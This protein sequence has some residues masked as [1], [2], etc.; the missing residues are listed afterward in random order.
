MIDFYGGHGAYAPGLKRVRAYAIE[1]TPVNILD[2]RAPL[3][4]RCR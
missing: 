3:A 4:F 2:W 1:A